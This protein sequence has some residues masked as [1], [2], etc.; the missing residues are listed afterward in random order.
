MPVTENLANDDETTGAGSNLVSPPNAAQ[1]SQLNK[2]KGLE[3]KSSVNI[4]G[5][6]NAQSNA[7][8]SS[9]DAPGRRL[10]NPLGSLSSYTYQL[11]LYMITPD[12]YD[13]FIAS[14]RTQIDALANASGETGSGGAYLIAQSG[15]INNDNNQRAPGFDLDFYIDN[16][17]LK[18]AIS[19]EAT[20]SSSN[21]Y[22]VQFDILEPYGFSFN[23]KL[24]QASDDLQKYFNDTGYSKNGTIENPSRQFFILGAKFNG[25]DP[26]GNIVTGDQEFEGLQGAIDPNASGTS[27]FQV[28]YDI[29]ITSVKFTIEG[30]AVKYAISGVSTA[31]GTAFGTKRGRLNS[32]TT[33]CARTFDDALVGQSGILTQLHRIEAE[34]VESGTQELPN[35]YEVEY[36]GDGV[37]AI[38][39]ALLVLPVDTDKSKWCSGIGVENAG[40]ATDG[41]AA[42]LTPDNASRNIIF[43]KGTTFI[44]IFDDLLKGSSYM[45]DALMIMYKSEPI[46]DLDDPEDRKV[47]TNQTKKVGWYKVTPELSKA[48]WDPIKAD[49]AYTTTF[50]IERYETPIISSIGTN[51]GMDYYGPHKRYEY[52]WTGENREILEYSQK[53]DNL[54]YNEV[55]GNANINPKGVGTGGNA[56]IPVQV[57]KNTP[58]PKLNSLGAGGASQN[59]YVTSLYSPDS[60]A[61]A[62]ISLLGDPDFLVQEHRGGPDDLYNRFYG[63][64]GFRVSANG[65]QVFIEIDFKE[66][67]DYNDKT[68]IMDLNDSILFFK[69]PAWAEEKIK[70]V[71][72]KVVTVASTF[73]EGKFTQELT[74]VIN[75]F[76]NAD[77]DKSGKDQRNEEGGTPV[78]VRSGEQG[79][80]KTETKVGD[81]NFDAKVPEPPVTKEGGDA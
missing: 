50:R 11:S 22:D 27:I 29:K 35:R 70:G 42:V 45:Y 72:Y 23:T 48:K 81:G 9:T 14:G 61:Q 80:P 63:N 31:P 58:M 55:V 19:G 49:W 16:L 40:E 60:Y 20:Q 15:G 5:D 54:F 41:A 4:D 25:Y 33:I 37:E 78:N 77:T 6:G 2:N 1:E 21:V 68:G 52:W 66:A 71:S 51:P 57:Q 69:Y 24:K 39:D 43:N 67:I 65:G 62:K 47:D 30:G 34:L 38:K 73:A 46:P 36:I 44:E 3:S 64:D 53:L 76:P 7:N 18:H 32:T 59:Q 75:T 28:Y 17:R 12:A 56:Q 8:T 26:D 13:A 74:C 79:T 10:K